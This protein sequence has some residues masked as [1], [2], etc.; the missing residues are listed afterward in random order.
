MATAVAIRSGPASRCS[1]APGLPVVPPVVVPPVVVP[2]V[3][4]VE[5]P[6]PPVPP[7]LLPVVTVVVLVAELLFP[8]GSGVVE[9]TTAVLVISSP[10]VTVEVTVVLIVKP[11]EA[12]DASDAIVQVI[13]PSGCP[14]G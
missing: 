5:P 8:S 13:T 2:P 3:V 12:P 10:F 9:P 11:A 7:V 4:V 1:K 14:T 6:V